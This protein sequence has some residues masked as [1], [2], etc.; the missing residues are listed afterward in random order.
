M[1]LLNETHD[2]DLQ[3]SNKIVRKVKDVKELEINSCYEYL[4]NRLDELSVTLNLSLDDV[5]VHD[6]F[7]DMNKTEV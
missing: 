4:L 5:L 7:I 1:C 3:P 2:Y 6:D